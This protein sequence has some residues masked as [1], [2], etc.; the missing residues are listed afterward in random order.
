MEIDAEDDE[1]NVK[2]F[3]D[4]AAECRRLA[5]IASERDRDVLVEIAE[6]W[7]V[8]AEQAERESKRSQL[9]RPVISEPPRSR[10]K[11]QTLAGP[12]AGE[13]RALSAGASVPIP[14]FVSVNGALV[15]TSESIR[16]VASIC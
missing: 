1:A 13:L 6:A 14:K 4:Y 2:K 15:R 3:R 16:T 5:R 11:A 12:D 9:I 8:C 7:I 10:C